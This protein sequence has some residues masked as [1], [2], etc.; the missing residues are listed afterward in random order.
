MLTTD[1]RARLQKKLPGLVRAVG[2]GDDCGRTVRPV[3]F[4]GTA[5]TCSMEAI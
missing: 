2:A 1:R 5:L 3:S 4:T